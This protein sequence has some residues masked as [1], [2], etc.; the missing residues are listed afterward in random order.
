MNMEIMWVLFFPGIF[1]LPS[2]IC[3]YREICTWSSY[4][5]IY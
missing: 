1:T 4:L 3:K 5:C 2:Q